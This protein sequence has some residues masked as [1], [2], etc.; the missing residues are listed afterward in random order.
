M[1]ATGIVELVHFLSTSF[2]FSFYYCGGIGTV[3]DLTA[4]S[5]IIKTGGS[6]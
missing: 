5:D 1:D 2:A 6:L 4:G 3:I